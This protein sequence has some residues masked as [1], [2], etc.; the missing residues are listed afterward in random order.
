MDLKRIGTDLP[1]HLAQS[2]RSSIISPTARGD[3]RWPYC[4]NRR[5]RNAV[6]NPVILHPGLTAA[7]PTPDPSQR[8]DFDQLIG[9]QASDP[10]AWPNLSDELPQIRAINRNRSRYCVKQR[11]ARLGT[12][13]AT[14]VRGVKSSDSDDRGKSEVIQIGLALI[15]ALPLSG[16]SRAELQKTPSL[17][18]RSTW[19]ATKV[20]TTAEGPAIAELETIDT[21]GSCGC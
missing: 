5:S 20:T 7:V 4:R 12:A 9:R 19:K 3:V 10:G 2:S 1:I 6:R 21:R 11:Y 16:V 17:R 8:L 18:R 15:I 14:I 13:R